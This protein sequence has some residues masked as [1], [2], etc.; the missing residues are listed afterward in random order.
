MDKSIMPE[1]YADTL[2][3]QVLIPTKMGYN[4]QSGCF[5]V[6][7]EMSLGKF[8]DRFAVGII[9]NDKVQI[10]YLKKFEIIDKVGES[11]ILW[12]HNEKPIKH[13]YIIQVCPAL[14]K[15]IL[16]ICDEEGIKL[17][18][19]GLSDDLEALKKYTKSLSSMKDER[20]VGLFKAI[21]KKT[22]NLSVRKLKHWITLLKEKNYQVDIKALQNG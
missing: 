11:L 1:C 2:L 14:E 19:F 16:C 8:K 6:E 12:K 13:H 3:I 21:S 9:D 18:K 22:G 17:A 15:W 4:H 10:K 20:L 7:R 5:E